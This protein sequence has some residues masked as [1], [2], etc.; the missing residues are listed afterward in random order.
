LASFYKLIIQD[1]FVTCPH[2]S[3]G[4]PCTALARQVRPDF[5]ILKIRANFLYHAICSTAYA[6][7][8]L[9]IRVRDEGTAS[10]LS[11]DR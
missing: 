1:L 2:R 10:R 9:R 7:A 3:I 4:Y 6:L 8:S 11:R 5:P